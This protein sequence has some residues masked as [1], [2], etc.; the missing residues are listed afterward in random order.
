[1]RFTETIL[2]GAYLVELTPA[3]DSRGF[4]ARTFCIRE[5]G[6]LGLETNFVQLSLS[7]SAV[8]GTLRGMHFQQGPHGETKLVACRKGAIWDV[9]VDLRPDSPTYRQWL[10][11]E[12]T[13]VNQWQ[14]YIPRGFAHGF[15]TLCDDTEVQYMISAFY[16]PGAA[17]GVRYNDPALAI[18]WPLSTTV[19]SQQDAAWPDFD[20]PFR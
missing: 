11:F 5:F 15:Q 1:M 17:R 13:P 16:E 7:Q 18:D 10:G 12:L 6:E 8:K 2:S 19:I 9:I 14:L 3:R 4:F 20:R